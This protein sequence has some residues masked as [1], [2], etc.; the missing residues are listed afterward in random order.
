LQEKTHGVEKQR[1]SKH[2]NKGEWNISRYS[3]RRTITRIES[4]LNYMK[5]SWGYPLKGTKQK[6]PRKLEQFLE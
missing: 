4:T 6:K 3:T 5:F 1:G 2:I